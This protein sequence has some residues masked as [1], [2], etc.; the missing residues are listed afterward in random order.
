LGP[1]SCQVVPPLIEVSRTPPSK[2]ASRLKRWKKVRVAP[3]D[4]NGIGIALISVKLWSVMLFKSG[5]KAEKVPAWDAVL[6][7]VQPQPPGTHCATTEVKVLSVPLSKVSFNGVDG[8]HG[9][10][11]GV[12]VGV[13]GVGVGVGVG[14]AHI[15]AP[16]QP[17]SWKTWSGPPPAEARQ[18]VL[19]PQELHPEPKPPFGFCQAAPEPF[20]TVRS[21]QPHCPFGVKLWFACTDTQ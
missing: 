8:L 11:V 5:A 20:C 21:V 9:V 2:V 19:R 14:V 17:T 16:M 4:P 6:T 12:G 7:A 3:V 15:P 18:V 13:P 1:A 10:A